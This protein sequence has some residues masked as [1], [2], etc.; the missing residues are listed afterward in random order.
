MRQKPEG[1][2]FEMVYTLYENVSFWFR[3]NRPSTKWHG[4]SATY[5]L[6]VVDDGL[7]IWDDRCLEV[8]V[9][10]KLKAFNLFTNALWNTVKFL[11]CF[12]HAVFQL[13]VH[14]QN[15]Y[16]EMISSRTLLSADYSMC[17]AIVWWDNLFSVVL[18]LHHGVSSGAVKDTSANKK[19][20]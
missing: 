19:T 1:L 6:L 5:L 7:E 8:L 14:K 15:V 3:L 2:R 18:Y 20:L 4:T 11:L 10:L 17:A 16:R 9:P 12:F 13:P